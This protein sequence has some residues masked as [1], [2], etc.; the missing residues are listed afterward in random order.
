MFRV[1]EEGLR[2]EEE[3]KE[4]ALSREGTRRY[5]NLSRQKKK[6]DQLRTDITV[7]TKRLYKLRANIY[8]PVLSFS[9]L[10]SSERLL[11]ICALK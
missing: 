7:V 4:L 5:R 10:K 3:R 1:Q 6:N 11:C 2:Y 9:C 8:D